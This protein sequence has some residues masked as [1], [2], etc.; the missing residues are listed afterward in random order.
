M[1]TSYHQYGTKKVLIVHWWFGK[2]NQFCFISISFWSTVLSSSAD[3]WKQ[4][5]GFNFFSNSWVASP[6]ILCSTSW[7]TITPGQNQWKRKHEFT[8]TWNKLLNDKKWLPRNH[9]MTARRQGVI[10]LLAQFL[11]PPY[12]YKCTSL[13]YGAPATRAMSCHI[14]IHMY[15]HNVEP[16]R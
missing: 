13:P 9:K 6:P 5:Q 7:P 4:R 14:I 1:E 12:S 15:I 2:F 8:V 11:G 16:P 10:C 3:F